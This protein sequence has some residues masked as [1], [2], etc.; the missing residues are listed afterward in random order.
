MEKKKRGG[1]CPAGK[2]SRGGAGRVTVWSLLLCVWPSEKQ[3]PQM[4]TKSADDKL[5]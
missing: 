2:V 1:L 4:L 5:W 3:G